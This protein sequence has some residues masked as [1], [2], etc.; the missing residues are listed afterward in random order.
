M[1]TAKRPTPNAT[2]RRASL[3]PAHEAAKAKAAVLVPLQGRVAEAETMGKAAGAYHRALLEN[4]IPA[5]VAAHMVRDWAVG[6]PAAPGE[7]EQV[8][9]F[10]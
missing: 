8:R 3:R 4:G 7:A 9:P 6:G 5:P 2:R 10:A 1:A